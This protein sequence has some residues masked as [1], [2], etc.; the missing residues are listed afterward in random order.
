MCLYKWVLWMHC[1]VLVKNKGGETHVNTSWWLV[2][3][4]CSWSICAIRVLMFVKFMKRAQRVHT[5]VHMHTY[6]FTLV[7]KTC[8]WTMWFVSKTITRFSRTWSTCK[9][10]R[11]ISLS[12]FKL[13]D[14]VQWNRHH[15][16]I[17]T[18][19]LQV[20]SASSWYFCNFTYVILHL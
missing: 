18:I 13:S 11:S 7:S 14:K 8:S 2:R 6:D 15:R 17:L 1:T 10:A 5:Y 16:N 12:S 4:V 19:Q 9:T 3:S 20:S